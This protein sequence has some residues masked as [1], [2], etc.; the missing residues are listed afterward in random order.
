MPVHLVTNLGD[1]AAQLR[2]APSPVVV[3]PVYNSYSDVVRCV[4]S[5]LTHTAPDIAVLVIDDGSV[6]R[7]TSQLLRDRS[8]NIAHRLVM[9]ERAGNGG[10]V[11]A[12]NEAFAA[13][14]GRDVVLVNSDVV[15]GA[16]WLPRLT[17]AATSSDI[18]A[19]ATTLT[20]H[21]SIVSVP[22]RDR[23]VSTL[24]EH[25]TPE[26]AARR[27]AAASLRLRPVIPTAV[28]HCMYIRR[29][30]LDL[31]GGFDETFSPGYGEEVDFCQRAIAH[32]YRHVVADDVFTFHRG[33]GSFGK[34][35][36]SLR[37]QQRNDAIVR[38]RYPWLTRTAR[39][40]QNDAGSE[41][42]TAL[43]VASRAL[44]GLTVGID[45]LCLG[46]DRLGTQ[47][48][49][50]E[51]I[52]AL[53]TRPEIRRLVAFV[54]MNPGPVVHRLNAEL[55]NV[56]FVSIDIWAGIPDRVVDVLY[57][58]Y[59]VTDPG[60]LD[61]LRR[62]GARFVV[63]QLDTIAFDNPAYFSDE[64]DWIR[65]RDLTRMTV[66]LAGGVAFISDFGRRSAASVGLLPA[67][68]PNAV[69]SCGADA[70]EESRAEPQPV[71]GLRDGFLLCL[72]ASYRHKNRAFSLDVWIELRRRG[73]D[74]QLVFAG[75]TPP[76]GNSLAA[77]AERFLAVPELR[78]EVVDLGGVSDAQREW[79]YGRA[80]LALY[81]SSVEGFGMVP[82][83]AAHRGVPTLSTRCGSLDEV[84]PDGIPVIDGFDVMEAADA[85]HKLLHDSVA[86]QRLVD[87]L[88][89][90]SREFTWAAT[91]QR[92]VVL[93]ED[94]LAKPVART[95]AIDGDAEDPVAVAGRAQSRF[96]GTSRPAQR[97][98]QVVKAAT[99]PRF[100][101]LLKTVVARPQLKTV[102]SRPGS[103]RQRFARGAIELVRRGLN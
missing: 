74:G 52:R 77:E 46:P 101:Q 85:A 100:E 81:P 4:E 103:A 61:F 88:V 7:R 65:Y 102:L 45:A 59:Q 40:T 18:V 68:K 87:Q 84:L 1:A 22:Y 34:K 70:T 58:P 90:R 5:V 17:E 2:D 69:V 75:P 54:P 50:V 98:E 25:M 91:A 38:E 35:S 12:C 57:R 37:R 33:G 43:G 93:F 10:F 32:G 14:P 30:V 95:V 26:D 73:Y 13:T 79:L 66:E 23:P 20:N 16:E 21:G 15:V 82:F 72:G 39:L 42:E 28:G 19:T 96:L 24:P 48:N 53:A 51:T 47:V 76:H 89:A 83:E 44:L 62:A 63:N 67:G 27:V 49:T 86:A 56:E 9:F 99:A 41:L 55:P 64:D 60:E 29:G 3:I 71:P 78:S 36:E 8:A 80:G 11:R 97:F 6:D 92:L 31:I 94:A